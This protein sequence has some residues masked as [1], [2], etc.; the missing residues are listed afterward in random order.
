MTQE[1]DVSFGGIKVFFD[2]TASVEDNAKP[3]LEPVMPNYGYLT[4][5]FLKSTTALM[6]T[7]PDPR[8]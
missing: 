1:T 7:L 6:T 5:R 2:E 8:K 4:R 3:K